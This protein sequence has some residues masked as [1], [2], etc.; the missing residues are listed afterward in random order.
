MKRISSETIDYTELQE[1]LFLGESIVNAA[2]NVLDFEQFKKE[3][4]KKIREYNDRLLEDTETINYVDDLN[5]KDVRENKNLKISAKKISEKDKEIRR[6]RK[7]L[8]STNKFEKLKLDPLSVAFAEETLDKQL[9]LKLKKSKYAADK[10]FFNLVNLLENDSVIFDADNVNRTD[11]AKKREIEHSTLY[12]FSSPFELLHVDVR[13]LE[14]LGNNATFPRY[15]LVVVDLFSSK[16][17]TYMMKSR[18]QVKQ[19]LEQFYQEVENKRKGKE[20]K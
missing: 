11:Y 7:P 20:T 16:V 3:Q 1:D 4:E 19:K 6:K 17:Y 2:I 5:L 10:N 15:V 9:L 8:I 13:N 12:S 14:F 18:K